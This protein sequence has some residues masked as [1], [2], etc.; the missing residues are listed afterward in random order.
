MAVIILH[1]LSPLFYK[2][3]HILINDEIYGAASRSDTVP[4][5][6][7]YIMLPTLERSEW[8]FRTI[9][10][11]LMI[12]YHR[13]AMVNIV[14]FALQ[15]NC[16]TIYRIKFHRNIWRGTQVRVVRVIW[17]FSNINCMAVGDDRLNDCFVLFFWTFF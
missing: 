12:F 1:R 10:K 16:G 7:F 8:S 15:C 9:Y 17:W 4:L 3:I 13:I 14:F 5:V 11:I 6:T 2:K